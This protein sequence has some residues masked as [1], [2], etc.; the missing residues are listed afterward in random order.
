[1]SG[2]VSWLGADFNSIVSQGQVIARLDASSLDAQRA[3]AEAS[4][5]RV[6]AEVEQARVQLADARQKYA[7]ASELN[8]RQLLARS[9]FD[10]ASLGVATSQAQLKSVEAQLVQAEAALN[11][12]RVNLQHAVIVSPID[13]IVIERS[14]DVGQ[15]V[16][17]S[18]Q[19]PTIFKIAADMTKMQVNASIDESD[20]GRVAAGQYVSFTV[21]AYPGDTFRGTMAQVRL[22][23]AVVQNVT[24]YSAIIDVPNPE[25]KLKPGMTATVSVEIARRNGVLRVPNTA[26]RFTPTAE[27]LAALGGTAAERPRGKGR[28]QEVWTYSGSTLAAATIT[29]GLTDGQFTEVVAGGFEP[30]ARIVTGVTP[31]ARPL[32]T[33]A[34]PGIFMPGGTAGPRSRPAGGGG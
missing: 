10:A 2:T 15:T 8:A 12:A 20:I 11:Q 5:A 9:E 34:S 31:E 29:S 22:Q 6:R 1:V 4:L 30:G 32:R 3:Q 33:A 23:P 27:M 28:D 25:L 24:T 17:A 16:A 26:L 14:V 7:R 18:L 21:D 19:S 13:G